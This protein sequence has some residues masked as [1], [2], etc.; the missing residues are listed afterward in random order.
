VENKIHA[1]EDR[2]V[3]SMVWEGKENFNVDE[4]VK[5]VGWGVE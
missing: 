3:K 1:R 2:N 4:L 5:L